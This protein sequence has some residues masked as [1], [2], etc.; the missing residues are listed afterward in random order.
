MATF[1]E[2]M[3]GE[4]LSKASINLYGRYLTEFMVFM[5]QDGT[6]IDEANGK[7]VAGY[8]QRLQRRELTNAT[9]R[10]HLLVLKK[11]FAWRMSVGA[12]ADNPA[13]HLKMR[14]VERNKLHTILSV[15][16]LEALHAGY[17]ID[18]ESSEKGSVGKGYS[19]KAKWASMSKMLRERNKVMIGL[20][21][22]QGMTT[23]E[24]A[25]LN[26][27][28]LRLREGLLDVQAMKFSK[29]RTLELK[30]TQIMELA[31]YVQRV[32]AE[33]L[34][35]HREGEQALFLAAPSAGN[36]KAHGGSLQVWKRLSE[37]LR[38]Q[39]ERFQDVQQVRASV[40]THWL[41]KHGLRQVQYMAGHRFISSTER[42]QVGQIADLQSD[43]DRFHPIG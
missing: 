29:A 21:V 1:V 14:G 33:L 5:D 32:R 36:E 42:Y 23:T 28:D 10:I 25:T 13:E 17:T 4:G 40:I 38:Q 18:L 15:Q 24:I 22:H 43:I 6:D 11:F 39:C 12:R 31:D 2:H 20:L 35:F 26:V 3:E 8:L 37:E 41:G 9:R 7:H 16:E 19:T 30:A 27:Q 34:K